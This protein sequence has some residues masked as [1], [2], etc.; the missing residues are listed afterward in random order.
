MS[1][2]LKSFLEAVGKS[3]TLQEKMKAIPKDLPREEAVQKAIAI[4]AEAGFQLSEAD[5][6][7]GAEA[8]SEE[9]LEAVAGGSG[10]C[11]CAGAG[12]GSGVSEAGNKFGCG[13]VLYGQGDGANNQKKVC[14]CSI[15]GVGTDLGCAAF[16]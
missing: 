2:T 14:M 12:G 7:T 4:A 6:N 11:G 3:E 9:E 16:G 15:G 10:G 13:C 1:D 5:L 8:I